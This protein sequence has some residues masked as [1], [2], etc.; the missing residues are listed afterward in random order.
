MT[1]T[2]EYFLPPG[3]RTPDSHRGFAGLQ[4][5]QQGWIRHDL[6]HVD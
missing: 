3:G 2:I 5:T 4:P 1:T 6:I